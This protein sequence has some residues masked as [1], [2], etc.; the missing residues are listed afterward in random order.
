MFICMVC[1]CVFE[2]ERLTTVGTPYTHYICRYAQASNS[3]NPSIVWAHLGFDLCAGNLRPLHTRIACAKVESE[4]G[5]GL[6]LSKS[7]VCT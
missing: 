4:V 6:G 1:V 3:D 5:T 2:K 7:E